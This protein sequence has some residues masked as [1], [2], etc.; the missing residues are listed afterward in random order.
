V[1]I[2]PAQL[3][4]GVLEFLTERHLA[5]LTTLP[6][7]A[8]MVSEANLRMLYGSM[9][10]SMRATLLNLLNNN[11][12]GSTATQRALALVHLIALSP[13]FATQR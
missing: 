7:N 1:P 10:L 11:M 4:P 5:S 12:P 3:S 8:A 2:D 9:S 13:E 6:D